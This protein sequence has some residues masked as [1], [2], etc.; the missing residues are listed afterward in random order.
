MPVMQSEVLVQSATQSVLLTGVAPAL[1]LRGLEEFNLTSVPDIEV[2]S[3]LTQGL[4]GGDAAVVQGMSGKAS[5]SGWCTYQ[6][7]GYFLDNLL[8]Q[9]TPSG[10]GP[11][12]RNYA[13]PI[14]SAPSPRILSLYKGDVTVG[15]YRMVGSLLSGLT[16]KLA[17]KKSLAMSGDFV[18]VVVEPQAMSGVLSK[19]AIT[20]IL[21]SQVSSLKLD[22]F[23]GTMGATT[24]TNCTLRNYE[25]TLTPSRDIRTC[26]GAVTGA[27]YVEMPWTGRLKVSLEYNTTTKADLDTFVAGT[28]LQKQFEVNFAS[29]TSSLK[30]QFAGTVQNDVQIFGDDDGVTVVEFDMERTYQSTFGNWFKAVL[31]NSVSGAQML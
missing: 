30:L 19:P 31:V 24:L 22:T 29:G 16:I 6:H 26:V 5:F 18:G 2:L 27:S 7:I 20:P 17:P 11:Y 23:A 25:L 14:N 4:S 28:L 8:G 3:D 15:G 12:T 13:A 10:A 9:A 1:L 21:A